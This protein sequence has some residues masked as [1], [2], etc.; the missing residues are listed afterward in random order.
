MPNTASIARPRPHAPDPPRHRGR[1]MPRR[2]AFAPSALLL[3]AAVYAGVGPGHT[4]SAAADEVRLKSGGVLR[5]ELLGNFREGPRVRLRTLAGAEVAVSR[6]QI[7]SLTR[8]RLEVER[9]EQRAARADDTAAAWWELAGWAA[10]QR[11]S[12]PR[13]RALG[14]VIEL[15]PDHPAARDALGYTH[16]DGRWS[17]REDRMRDRGLVLHDGKWVS[18]EER[19]L[20]AA[21]ALENSAARAWFPK[22]RLWHGWWTGGDATRAARGRRNL[23][24]VRDPDA[25][26]ALSHFLSDDG[27]RPVR[28]LYVDL[29]GLLD[30]PDAAA[31]LVRQSLLDVDPNLRR[32]A[33]ASLRPGRH[34]AARLRYR[35]ALG[36]EENLV[37][38]R[39]GVALATLGDD[40]AVPDLIHALVTTHRITVQVPETG[41]TSVTFGNGPVLPPAV[42]LG[43]RAGAYPNGVIVQPPAGSAP[44]RT[45]PVRVKRTWENPEVR[46]A[47]NALTGADFGFDE[48]AW[49]T[50]WNARANGVPLGAVGRRTPSPRIAATSTDPAPTPPTSGA[51]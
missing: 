13:T 31:A 26:A 1:T 2:P 3:A 42:E 27:G 16:V 12:E 5:G 7:S 33:T 32:R 35:A 44:V 47:L 22:V 17:T 15:E 8:R 46:A 24:A 30:T 21:D 45:R 34:D 23:A 49:M 14:R 50:W 51:A 19:E 20:L 37:V 43:L 11:L 9:F 10:E 39:A 40:E 41:T 25:V 38:R 4:S 6:G 28:S 18:P 29:L 36:H 48:A